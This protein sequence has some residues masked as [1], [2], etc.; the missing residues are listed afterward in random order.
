VTSGIV[1][2]VG[3]SGL[4]GLGFQNF[5]QT[6]ASI[7]PGNSGGA[8]VNLRGE[9]VGINTATFN[10]Q[11]S[12]AGDIGLGFAIPTNL[13]ANV[14]RQLQSTGEVRRGTLGID[15]Q[16]VDERIAR[17]LGLDAAYGA[18]VTRVYPQ[19]AAAAAG[20]KVGDHIVTVGNTKVNRIEQLHEAVTAAP[21]DRPVLI[22]VDRQ[23]TPFLLAL[24]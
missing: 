4:P 21:P 24:P 2:A 20:L 7:N 11:G 8:L 3:R 18:V 5:I 6:D 12:R 22:E 14:M 9:L 13:A 17:G 19:S 15:T 16:T 1:S 10:P 23:G